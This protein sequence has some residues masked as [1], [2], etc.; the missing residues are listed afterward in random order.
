MINYDYSEM[1]YKG[2]INKQFSILSDDELI[3]ITNSELHQEEFTLKESLCSQQNLTFG[4]CEASSINFTV[5]NVFL[6][7]KD[8]W[9]TA[10]I[11]S[12]NNNADKPFQ[13]GRYKVYS[14]KPTADRT[15][16]EITAY[17]ALY[18]ILNADVTDWYNE[19]LPNKDTQ[20]SL[21]AFRNSFLKHFGIDEVE[22]VLPNDNMTVSR[23]IEPQELSGK[24]VITAI[25]EINGCF[26]HINRL[27]KFCYVFLTQE[28]QGLYPADNLYPANDLYPRDSRNYK[29]GKATY[30]SS[31]YEDY[32]VKAIN[33]LQIRQ[34]E[35]DIG[36]VV[37]DGSNAYIV[38][39]N[40]LVYG[41]NNEELTTI[42]RNM[43]SKIRGVVYRPFNAECVGNPC[44]EVGDAI[45]FNTKYAIIES[46]VLARTL[47]GIQQ[48]NDKYSATGD[49]LRSEKVNS[50][51]KQIIQLK[52][53]TNELTR[54][55]D[56]TKSKITD[57]EKGLSSEISQTASQIRSEVK[58]TTDG[59]STQITQ[60]K[61]SISAEVKRASESEGELSSKISQ[62]AEQITSE[63]KRA[64]EAEGNLS[65]KITQTADSISTK[66]SKNNIISEINQSAEEIQISA[67]KIQLNGY[68]TF[69][70]LSTSG[71]TTINGDNI[72][73][74]HL[75]AGLINSGTIRGKVGFWVESD[76]SD[77]VV[78]INADGIYNAANTYLNDVAIYGS[79]KDGNGND[80]IP[81]AVQYLNDGWWGTFSTANGWTVT[82]QNGVITDVE[83]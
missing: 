49:E 36:I 47:T 78:T 7:M 64:T 35:N 71:Q 21:K 12:L 59:L 20:I 3:S 38:E 6:P 80:L 74:G 53:K 40:F 65:S 58:D 30:K 75:N 24:A 31:S 28:M 67:E 1:F 33:K 13:I 57:V 55:V 41:K 26:G 37:G 19:T 70:E 73:T 48:L 23:T 34:K 81:A 77:R 76:S 42:A 66:V 16:R 52:G 8:K 82:V 17:D 79:L 29:L 18:D 27:G 46:Y 54:T 56:E 72:T 5:S 4:C 68:V 63:V 51:N 39:N 60:N 50:I 32:N 22:I 69:S 83:T 43:L 9:L 15:K 11:I 62:T 44:I 2:S 25:C 14:D 10:K 61:D 45:R